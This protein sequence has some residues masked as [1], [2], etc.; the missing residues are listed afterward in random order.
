MHDGGG[1]HTHAHT[2]REPCMLV[3][4]V[5]MIKCPASHCDERLMSSTHTHTHNV[6]SIILEKLMFTTDMIG[7]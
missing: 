1:R 3:A 2:T 7:G 6:N 4:I 5:A